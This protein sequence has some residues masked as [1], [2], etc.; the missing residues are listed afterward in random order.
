MACGSRRVLIC[1][2]RSIKDKDWVFDNIESFW[3]ENLA[4]FRELTLL[5]GEA[6]GVDKLAK[7][8]AKINNWENIEEYPADWEKYGRRAGFIRNEE[9]VKNCDCCLILWDGNSKGTYS[10]IEL[11]KKYKVPYTII[12]YPTGE[13][14]VYKR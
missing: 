14:Y 9:M 5:E 13:K 2:S 4:C 11:C 6:N 3:Y 8:Y 12:H 10:D 7:E 1:G